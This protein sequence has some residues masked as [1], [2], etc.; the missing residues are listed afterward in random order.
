VTLVD[1]MT[2]GRNE[3]HFS[4]VPLD[5]HRLHEPPDSLSIP[6]A[7]PIVTAA[8]AAAVLAAVWVTTHGGA[9]ALPGASFHRF[10][11]LPANGK[12]FTETVA[13]GIGAAT[14]TDPYSMDQPGPKIPFLQPVQVPCK[15]YSPIAPSIGP[16]GYWY[17]IASPPW[18][19]HCYAPANSFLNGDAPR[20]PLHRQ[21]HRPRRTRLPFHSLTER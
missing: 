4:N 11:G 3:I 14:F 16:L 7:A 12:T 19:N 8:V 2:T 6:P 10:I 20:G 21:R 15:V 1:C 17:R 9:F 5:Q 13:S 18:N